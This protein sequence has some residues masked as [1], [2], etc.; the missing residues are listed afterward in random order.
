MV[1]IAGSLGKYHRGTGPEGLIFSENEVM[2][3]ALY[4][5][6]ENFTRKCSVTSV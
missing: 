3:V 4:C 5:S 1:T 2:E 6:M